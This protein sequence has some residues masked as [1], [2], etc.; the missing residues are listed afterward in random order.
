[1]WEPD[2]REGWAPKN[3]CFWIVVLEKALESPLD[4]KKFKP[5][6]AKEINPEYSL[7]GLMLMLKLQYFGHLIWRADSL[8]KT[9]M[10]GRFEDMRRR[11]LQRTRWFRHHRL[12]GY[13]FE[14]G[15]G[16]CDGQGSLVWS[17]PCDCKQS[18]TTEQLNWL[19]E[20]R[21]LKVWDKYH[22]NLFGLYKYLIKC[23]NI[24]LADSTLTKKDCS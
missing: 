2:H 10:L 14:Q 6:N 19:T 22:L 7:D 15:L 3:W 5:V 17:S 18:N 1:M 13:E 9:L 12:D 11:G 24:H 23:V 8:E 16:V 21:Y 20:S 4:C